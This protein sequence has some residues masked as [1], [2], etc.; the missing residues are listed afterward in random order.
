MGLYL[1]DKEKKMRSHADRFIEA[2]AGFDDW[3][4]TTRDGSIE[5]FKKVK[6]YFLL[7]SSHS[8]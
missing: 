7:V 8:K 2:H 3:L 6:D 1:S 5:R 4:L